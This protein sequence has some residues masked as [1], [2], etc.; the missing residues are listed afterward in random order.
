MLKTQDPAPKTM[1]IP[2]RN[3]YPLG[4]NSSG[5]GM[6]STLDANF[7]VH[8]PNIIM[9]GNRDQEMWPGGSPA[10]GMADEMGFDPNLNMSMDPSFQWE[11]IGLGLQEPLPPQETIDEL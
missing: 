8:S 10:P 4:G 7:T 11:L 6:L 5:S 3:T 9:T 2:H 1:R